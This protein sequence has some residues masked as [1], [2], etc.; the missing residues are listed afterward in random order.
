MGMSQI[1]KERRLALNYTQEELASKVGLQKSAIA[2]YENGRVENMKRSIIIKMAEA[3]Q[4]SPAHLM[5]WETRT[6]LGV[7][8]NNDELTPELKDFFD[9][10]KKASPEDIRLATEMLKRMSESK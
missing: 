4:C 7:N 8:A 10:C 1:I 6:E 9:A 5:G 3:L 2:K